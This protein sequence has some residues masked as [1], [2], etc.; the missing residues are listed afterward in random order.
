MSMR[1]VDRR[2]VR[3][4][5]TKDEAGKQTNKHL[6]HKPLTPS[7]R[8]GAYPSFPIEVYEYLR[9][10]GGVGGIRSINAKELPESDSFLLS[11]LHVFFTPETAALGSDLLLDISR[12][13]K[14]AVLCFSYN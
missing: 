11:S 2:T 5:Q 7:T 3:Q 13:L 8:T 12:F 1:T 14:M 10:L 4:N 9:I 6:H